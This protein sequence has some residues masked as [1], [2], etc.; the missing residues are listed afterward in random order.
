MPWN[1]EQY[2]KFQ[3]ERSAPFFDLLELVKVKEKLSVID[4]GCG[5]GELTKI[6][7]ERLP[8]SDVLGIDNSPEMLSKASLHANTQLR[9]ERVSIEEISGQWDLVFSNAAIQWVEDHEQLIPK[10]IAL[11]RPGGQLVVQLPS[12]HSHPSHTKVLQPR[13]PTP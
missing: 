10:L 11:V 1:P 9:F 12:N 3:S 7:A 2:H 6:L 4:L 5:T 13:C 8:K